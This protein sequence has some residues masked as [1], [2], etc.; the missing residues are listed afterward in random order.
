[1]KHLL[2]LL[3]FALLV[4]FAAQAQDTPNVTGS[5]SM[6]VETDA[7]SG[8]PDFVLKQEGGKITGTYS[9]QLGD[10]PVTG[11]IK[12]N[13]IHLEFSVQGNRITYDGKATST[14]MEGKVNLAEMATGTFKG[15]KKS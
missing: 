12:G 4:N 5:W 10:A 15:K 9:G 3:F 14:E 1:M 6:S 2:S 8:N 13:V 7:G 11:T